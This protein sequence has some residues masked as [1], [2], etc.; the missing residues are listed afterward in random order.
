MLNTLKFK[1]R[2]S[3][4]INEKIGINALRRIFFV[5][6]LFRLRVFIEMCIMTMAIE[7]KFTYS[8]KIS[9]NNKTQSR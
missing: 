4:R 3:I 9:P 5:G 6:S 7:V 8:K 2:L 1:F